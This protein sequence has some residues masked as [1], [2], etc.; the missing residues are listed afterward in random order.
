MGIDLE[1]MTLFF[2][3]DVVLYR[4]SNTF[5]SIR[6]DDLAVRELRTVVITTWGLVLFGIG[7]VR[8]YWNRSGNCLLEIFMVIVRS[9]RV[10]RALYASR[11]PPA[12]RC[13]M[14]T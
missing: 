1:T 7:V 12:P 13:L 9:R 3:P 2:L 14:Q 8:R 10:S 6:Y 5:G 4:Q 11:M